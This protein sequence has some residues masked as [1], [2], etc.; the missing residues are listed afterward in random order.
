MLF[1][2]G[3]SLS[4]VYSAINRFSDDV[5]VGFDYRHLGEKFDPFLSGASRTGVDK[6][7]DRLQLRVKQYAENVIIPAFKT[8]FEE[9]TPEP[10]GIRT[11]EV[12]EKIWFRYPSVAETGGPYI[13]REVLLELGSRLIA[14][15]C[16]THTIVPDLAVLPE[17]VGFPAARVAVMPLGKTLWE[18][19]TLIHVECNRARKTKIPERYSRHWHDVAV[20][21]AHPVGKAALSDRL[22]LAEV[23]RHK[24]VFFHSSYACYDECLR[25]RARLLPDSG[26]LLEL[27]EDYKQ[28]RESGILNKNALDFDTV[29]GRVCQVEEKVNLLAG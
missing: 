15:P 13:K 19:I 16:E 7:C 14:E 18:K 25:G 9:A 6:F 24:K 22:L 4:K 8:A 12:C 17:R 28:M 21:F 5:D 29:I 1:K 11:D 2:G 27:K 3:T 10:N 26:K 23:V 20:L